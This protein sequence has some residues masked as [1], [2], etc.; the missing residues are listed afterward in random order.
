MKLAILAIVSFFF[1]MNSILAAKIDYY[2]QVTTPINEGSAVPVCQ[3]FDEG[4]PDGYR[5]DV[6]Y[7]FSSQDSDREANWSIA[8]KLDGDWQVIEGHSQGKFSKVFESDSRIHFGTVGNRFTAGEAN[9]VC[10]KYAFVDTTN[11]NELCLTDLSSCGKNSG[12]NFN[13]GPYALKATGETVFDAIRLY[14]RNLM[15]SGTFKSTLVDQATKG[16]IEYKSMIVDS[17]RKF[18]KEKYAFDSTYKYPSW[19]ETYVTKVLEYSDPDGEL[20]NK[21][22]AEVKKDAIVRIDN[23]KAMG[24]ITPEEAQQAK[25]NVNTTTSVDYES[26]TGVKINKKLQPSGC[27]D[28]NSLLGPNLTKVVQNIFNTIKFAGPI[29]VGV[30]TMMD[31]LKAVSAGSQEEIKKSSQKFIKRVAAAIVLFFVPTICEIL[32]GFAN[33]TAPPLCLD[34]NIEAECTVA[35]EETN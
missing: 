27:P 32:F 19:V 1:G 2:K 20:Y 24:I 25:D 9:F 6:Y 8:Y 7:Y 21:L 14:A 29:L 22:M 35:A 33:I 30:F 12:T 15:T 4:K 3:Y 5:V 26:A 17:T 31:F 34:K 11:Y 23:Q 28:C 18:I 16:N 10:P 13:H